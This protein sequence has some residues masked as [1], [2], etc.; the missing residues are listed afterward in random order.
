MAA[1]VCGD[2]ESRTI[3]LVD[4]TA[5][6]AAQHTAALSL[7]GGGGGREGQPLLF[8]CFLPI[9]LMNVF[10]FEG[11]RCSVRSWRDGSSDRSFIG[12]TH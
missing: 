7:R 8:V 2:S 3:D 5:S 11:A 12:W 9:F 6:V 10:F 4:K 1:S